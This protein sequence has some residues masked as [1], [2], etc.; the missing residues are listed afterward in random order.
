MQCCSCN[1]WFPWEYST[2]SD[3]RCSDSF[4][5]ALAT[6]V[7]VASNVGGD[8]VQLAVGI[9]PLSSNWTERK[10]ATAS[11]FRATGTVRVATVRGTD[12]RQRRHEDSDQSLHRAS[13]FRAHNQLRKVVLDQAGPCLGIGSVE[14]RHG[15]QPNEHP[16]I[17]SDCDL[18]A[19]FYAP[20]SRPRVRSLDVHPWTTQP[21]I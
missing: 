21:R 18:A 6:W 10:I 7:P 1:C 9:H 16:R 3:A 8:L 13:Q 19:V 15:S 20:P 11:N 17:T 2:E 4:R 14:R 5:W 12:H